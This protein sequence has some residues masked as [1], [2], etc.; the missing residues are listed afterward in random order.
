[1][2]THIYKQISLDSQFI[3]LVYSVSLASLTH[4]LTLKQTSR[5]SAGYGRLLLTISM[6][7]LISNTKTRFLEP[8]VLCNG[9]RNN[10]FTAGT[11][12]YIINWV[13]DA[14]YLSVCV[15]T[16]ET[17]IL[18]N[19]VPIN[20][21]FFNLFTLLQLATQPGEYYYVELKKSYIL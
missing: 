3:A 9:Y 21:C 16:D 6:L 14:Q 19:S 15:F 8:F 18:L 2:S 13:L 20:S 7:H 10:F 12:S 11:V 17:L 1:M 4:Q 5:S